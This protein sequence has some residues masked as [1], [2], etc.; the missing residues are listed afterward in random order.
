M[1][2]YSHIWKSGL[3]AAPHFYISQYLEDVKDD[4]IDAMRAV[5]ESG[6]WTEWIVFFMNAI[7]GQAALNA[8]K[9]RAIQALYEEMKGKFRETLNSPWAITAQDF[10]FAN[11][12]FRNSRFT[13]SAG[14]PRATALRLSRA[15]LEAGLLRTVQP[16][17]GQRAALLSFQP[18]MQLVRV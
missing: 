14:I 10:I 13:S 4:Y 9:A 16:P 8:Y 6:E 17:S 15:L 1:L 3:I 7:A 12:V 11:P 5:S 18:L 2:C